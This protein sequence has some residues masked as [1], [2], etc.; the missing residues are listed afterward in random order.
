MSEWQRRLELG[1]HALSG[2]CDKCWAEA[3]A[4]YANGQGPYKSHA[5][6]YCA[7][8]K[9]YENAAAMDLREAEGT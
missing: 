4:L 7:V 6:A 1:G 2:R 9:K 3:A 5:E 8:L